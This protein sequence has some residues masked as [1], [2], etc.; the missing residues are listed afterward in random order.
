MRRLW[1]WQSCQSR[2]HSTPRQSVCPGREV[3]HLGTA[4]D[5][6][7]FAAADDAVRHAGPAKVSR[8]PADV[9][10]HPYAPGLETETTTNLL[11]AGGTLAADRGN[12]QP[13]VRREPGLAPWARRR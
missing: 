7:S 9:C 8:L 1:S 4:V 2:R 12:N 13:R 6:V 5:S 10:S 3:S 11:A